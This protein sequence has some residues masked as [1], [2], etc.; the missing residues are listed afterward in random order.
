MLKHF[1]G[2]FVKNNGLIHFKYIRILLNGWIHYKRAQLF[3][4]W[5]ALVFF[6]I[7]RW[8]RMYK[9]FLAYVFNAWLVTWPCHSLY[10]DK[11]LGF[12]RYVVPCAVQWNRHSCVVTV[13][14]GGTCY[15]NVRVFILNIV[16]F[17]A[18]TLLHQIE[19]E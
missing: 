14:E 16:I 12:T 15:E 8:N 2:Y 11:F 3:E 4:H 17:I 5:H 10:L 6:N 9:H 18:C 19:V 1:D 7:T 13:S